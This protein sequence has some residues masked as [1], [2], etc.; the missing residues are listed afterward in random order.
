MISAEAFL[1]E[2]GSLR[3]VYLLQGEEPWYQ[4]QVRDRIWQLAQSSGI[5]SRQTWEGEGAQAHWQMLDTLLR[6]DDLFGGGQF[7]QIMLPKGQA[8][9]EGSEWIRSW[10]Q[11]PVAGSSVLIV[12]GRL[13]ARQLKSAWVQAIEQAGLVIQARPVPSGQLPQWAHQ[14]AR[15]Y[16]LQLTEEAAVL[17]AERSE[18]NLLALD[19]ALEI[20]ALRY[21]TPA[22]IEAPQV[23]DTIADQAHY[24]L[25]ALSDAILAGELEQALHVLHRLQQEGLEVPLIVWLLSRELNLFYQLAQ[26]PEQA[27]VLFRA[28]KIWRN[29]QPLYRQ[30]ARHLP[31]ETWSRLLQQLH[32]VDLQ[33]KGLEAGSPWRSLEAM[34]LTMMGTDVSA[35][36]RMQM[37]TA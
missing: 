25:F 29:R 11:A 34:L 10:C 31:V 13:E 28:Q 9:R 3:P 8:G 36:E 23:I 15:H 26:R 19:Q 21:G 5:Q 22:R 1:R 7:V 33:A 4:R 24:D 20:L 30:R 2:P 18:G 37:T 27:E 35:S 6:T 14:R 17:L 16:A 32:R 12:A